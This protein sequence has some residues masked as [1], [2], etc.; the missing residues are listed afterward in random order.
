VGRLSKIELLKRLHP[1]QVRILDSQFN[2]AP[3]TLFNL[4]L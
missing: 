4:S 3:F 1:G 2:R